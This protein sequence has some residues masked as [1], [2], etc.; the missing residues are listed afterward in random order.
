MDSTT[1]FFQ[2]T[3]RKSFRGSSLKNQ[4]AVSTSSKSNE[5]KISPYKTKVSQ[6]C[7]KCVGKRQKKKNLILSNKQIHVHDV[8][9]AATKKS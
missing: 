7:M 6:R 9:A 5:Y 4:M 8:T 1:P 3:G 2:F